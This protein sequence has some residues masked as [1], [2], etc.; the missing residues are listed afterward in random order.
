MR[1]DIESGRQAHAPQKRDQ[2]PRHHFG[3]TLE[4][5]YRWKT[6]I[7]KQIQSLHSIPV[8]VT[9]VRSSNLHA[10]VICLLLTQLSETCTK[11]WEMEPRDLL[12]KLF[13]Q[14][15]NVILVFLGLIHFFPIP[16]EI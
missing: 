8:S 1:M 14:Q 7:E 10:N 9:L 4:S 2:D 3:V 13:R 12:I 16:E 15:I 5:T 11:S 6:L